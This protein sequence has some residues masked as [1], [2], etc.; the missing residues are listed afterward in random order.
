MKDEKKATEQELIQDFARWDYLFEHG[1][2]DPFWEDGGSLNLL[3]N[4]I[5]YD[6]GK[7]EE[8]N[9]FPEIYF[10]SVPPEVDNKFMARAE[11]IRE[12]AK[13]SLNEYLLNADYL[14]LLENKPFIDKKTANRI[15]LDTVLGYVHGLQMY[16]E[17]D[18][19]VDMR[20]HENPEIYL[21]S[22]KT[23]RTNLQKFLR[24]IGQPVITEEPNG[25][26]KFN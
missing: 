1:G 9:Y 5:I 26:L 22:F 3:R 24:N 6:R 8:L 14:Y 25:Q 12:R 19:L 11:E 23:C 17:N 4:H 18:S 21:E 7:L 13:Q 16:I 10:R 2:Q 20:R 15:C